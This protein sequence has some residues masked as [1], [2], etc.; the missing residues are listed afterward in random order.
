MIRV[1]SFSLWGNQPRYTI[2]AI[3]NAQMAKMLYPEFECWFYIHKDTVPEIII[4]ELKKYDNVKIILKE[5]DL[6]S[7]K[8]M[9]WRFEAIDEPNVEVM[10]S[11]DTDTRIWER[12]VLAVR[13]WLKSDKIFHIMRDHPWHNFKIMAGMFGVK[14]SNITWKDKID[15][16]R[17]YDDYLYDQHFLQFIIYPLYINSLMIHATFNKIEGDIC[18]DF[19]ISLE[20]DDYRFVGEYVY[21]DESRNQQNIIEIKRGYI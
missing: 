10:L 19:P 11:R 8:P 21:E 9:M 20:D 1:V 4:N 18:R 14:K 15:S 12:E 16:F 17:Q 2:G 6:N 7:C 13:E 5:G 3:R